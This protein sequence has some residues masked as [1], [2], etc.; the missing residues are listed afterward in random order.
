MSDISKINVDGVDYDVKDT[1][2][3]SELESKFSEIMTSVTTGDLD[4]LND[5]G[6]KK[7]HKPKNFRVYYYVGDY[8]SSKGEER[9]STVVLGM[10]E[11]QNNY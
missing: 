8:F 7:K 6:M 1:T 2:A 5:I 10:C 4:N 9:R 3:R 11:K